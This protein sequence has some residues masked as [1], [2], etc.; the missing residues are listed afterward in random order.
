MPFLAQ[1]FWSRIYLPM[2]R[3]PKLDQIADARISSEDF[4]ALTDLVLALQMSI[5][6][7]IRKALADQGLIRN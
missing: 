4:T 6:Q 5:S 7:I 2:K 3:A 1:P